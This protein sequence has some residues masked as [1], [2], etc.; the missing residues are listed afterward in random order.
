MHSFPLDGSSSPPQPSGPW[1][2][3]HV[4]AALPPG[5]VLPDNH[6]VT[7]ALLPDLVLPDPLLDVLPL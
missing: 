7:P 3:D 2:N 4:D 5:L 1:P 6:E